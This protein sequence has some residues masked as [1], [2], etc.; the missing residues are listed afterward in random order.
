MWIFTAAP[1]HL[2]LTWCFM[3]PIAIVIERDFA[4]R[5]PKS[6]R[7]CMAD[8]GGSW[9]AM[10]ELWQQTEMPYL[11]LLA[12]TTER[13]RQGAPLTL[14]IKNTD[15]LRSSLQHCC[16]DMQ[17][18]RCQWLLLLEKDSAAKNIAQSELLLDFAPE[19]SA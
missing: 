9:P 18:Q 13:L 12:H 8:L 2:L 3:T 17:G 7:K 10:F 15:V 16:A 4:E 6:V 19:G 5:K 14:V 1:A 11:I